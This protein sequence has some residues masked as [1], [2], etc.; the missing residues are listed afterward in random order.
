M[1]LSSRDR[2]RLLSGWLGVSLAGLACAPTP[3]AKP[4]RLALKESSAP[5]VEA[6]PKDSVSRDAVDA[7][8]AAGL[9]KFLANVE[10]EAQL[11]KGKFVGWRIVALHGEMW[12]GVDL[13]VGDVVTRVNGFPIERDYEADK[14]FRSLAVASEIRVSYLRAGAPREL[15]FSIV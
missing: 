6:Q 5:V 11:D 12:K 8:V 10:V 14:A 15:R 2:A 13:E 1:A 7:T 3:E 4:S 9:G